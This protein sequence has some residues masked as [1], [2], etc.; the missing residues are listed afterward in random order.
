MYFNFLTKTNPEDLNVYR[1]YEWIREH[2]TPAGVVF[3][4]HGSVAIN[5]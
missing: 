4:G 1:K 2:S 5:M 3:P